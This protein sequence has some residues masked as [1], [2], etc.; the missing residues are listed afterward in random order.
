VSDPLTSR[1]PAAP[2]QQAGSRVIPPAGRELYDQ[3]RRRARVRSPA[4]PQSNVIGGPSAPA[5]VTRLMRPCLTVL[6]DGRHCGHTG[7]EHDT[8]IRDGKPARTACSVAT[9]AG[10][11]RCGLYAPEGGA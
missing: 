10:R 7:F 3:A 5:G 2:R 1:L 11:C 8:G 4:D 6:P 9:A